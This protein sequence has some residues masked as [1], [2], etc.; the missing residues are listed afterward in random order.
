MTMKLELAESQGSA[1]LSLEMAKYSFQGVA[2]VL[3]QSPGHVS[4]RNLSRADAEAM[5]DWLS[6]LL[7]QSQD[8]D[9]A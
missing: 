3:L 4:W 8:K 9:A 5:R 1:G 6:A 2:Q 7:A